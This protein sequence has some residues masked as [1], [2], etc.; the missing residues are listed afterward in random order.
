MSEP[1]IGEVRIWACN[2]APRGWATCDGSL[3]PISQNTALFSLLGTTYGGDGRS[4]F[5]IPKLDDRL[6]MHPGRG[7]G[8]TS[9]RLGET[10]GTPAV[11]LSEAQMGSHNH[12][13]MVFGGQGSTNVP[14]PTTVVAQGQG[15]GAAIFAANDAT[16]IGEFKE[17][18]D[19]AGGGGAHTN[20]QPSQTLLFCIALTGMYPSRG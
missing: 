14:G 4:T 12:H 1:F 5:G 2:F 11:T 17:L 8:L 19:T 10:G 15:R 18:A 9:R 13:A 7:P 20:E 6:P 16:G 3:L